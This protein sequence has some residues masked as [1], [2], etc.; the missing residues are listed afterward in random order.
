[1][2]RGRQRLPNRRRSETTEIEVAG[3]RVAAMVGFD[4]SGRP[5][6][7]FLSGAKDGSGL[8]AIMADASVVIS[9]GL[10]HGILAS[11][12][13]KSVGRLPETV[14][15]PAIPRGI[16]DRRGARLDRRLREGQ[17]Q[18]L[19]PSGASI[20]S[21]ATRGH[22]APAPFWRPL[23]GGTPLGH[24]TQ[25]PAGRSPHSAGLRN[26]HLGGGARRATGRDLS[27]ALGTVVSWVDSVAG[28]V[29][30]ARDDRAATAAL[31]LSF[32]K[33][34]ARVR[35][36]RD[37]PEASAT[38]LGI[39]HTTLSRGANAPPGDQKAEANGNGGGANGQLE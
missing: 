20:S 34:W 38:V 37:Q 8:A 18:P 15:G 7:L 28:V 9:V 14:D 1:M 32:A 13:R 6:E 36:D 21:A 31:R 29:L 11:E 39:A 4:P 10:Q 3:L 16:A 19:I 12:L 17:L 27:D 35:G 23:V 26:G 25:A 24:R 22:T 30:G 5:A 2:K 33:M